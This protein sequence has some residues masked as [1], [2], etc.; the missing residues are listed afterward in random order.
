MMVASDFS[1]EDLR[2]AFTSQGPP[3]NGGSGNSLWYYISVAG[4]F[5]RVCLAA[6]QFKATPSVS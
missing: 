5:R 2:I 6:L 3:I 4:R 1:R